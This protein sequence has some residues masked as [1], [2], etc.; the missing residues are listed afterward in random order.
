MTEKLTVLIRQ[1]RVLDPLSSTDTIADVLI[2][3]GIITA[4]SRQL[5][6]NVTIIEGKSL[7]LAPGLVDL[8][9]SSG[10]PGHEER[11]TLLS[12]LA[13][14]A[15]GGFTRLAILPNTIPP[16][17]NPGAIQALKQRHQAL[18]GSTFGAL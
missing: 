5:E 14:A 16:L 11:E 17:D 12:L 15:S 18:L 1:V 7:I 10:E 13:A 4:I 6:S 8:Y 2:E 9:S 3:K